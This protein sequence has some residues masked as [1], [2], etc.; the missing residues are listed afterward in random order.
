MIITCGIYLYSTICK[1]ILI[2]HATHAS[3]KT[4]SVP[5]GL[6]ELGEDSYAAAVREL[7]EETDVDIHALHVIA[8]HVLPAIKYQKQNK[9]IESFLVIS[10]SDMEGFKFKCHSL[11][12]NSFP[13]IDA[14]K[15]LSLESLTN[16][17]HESQQKNISLIQ[18][19]IA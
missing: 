15:W 11:I 12:N 19:L 4:W 13:E 5:K 9:T 10:D 17:L 1:K 8:V 16:V 7:K 3:W 18:N 2:C 6:K 14:W